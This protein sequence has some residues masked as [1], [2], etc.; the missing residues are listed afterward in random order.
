MYNFLRKCQKTVSGAQVSFEGKEASGIENE[1]KI[2][3]MG[4]EVSNILLFNNFFEK[5][6]IF[7]DNG[8][9][10]LGGLDHFL[11]EGVI[12]TPKMNITFLSKIRC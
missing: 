12:L 7:G 1:Y 11:G 9:K 2:F 8:G 3:F 4:N 10:I 5:S 6:N